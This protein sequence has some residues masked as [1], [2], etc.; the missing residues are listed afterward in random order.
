MV[1]KQQSDYFNNSYSKKISS[2]KGSKGLF[3][4]FTINNDFVHTCETTV[5]TACNLITALCLPAK[6]V[7]QVR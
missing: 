3:I 4:Y 7:I 6:K 2:R 1:I 5:I